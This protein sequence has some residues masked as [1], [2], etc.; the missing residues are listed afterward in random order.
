MEAPPRTN[1]GQAASALRPDFP[2]IMKKVALKFCGGCDPAYDR[3]QYWENIRST[4][5]NR[6]QWVRPE[7]EGYQVVLL[8]NGCMRACSEGLLLKPRIISL[9][10]PALDPQQVVTMIMEEKD[11]DE[12]RH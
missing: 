11:H 7:E 2:K 1:H 9:T 5:G 6:I 10:D 8:I 3:V 4:A 12:D